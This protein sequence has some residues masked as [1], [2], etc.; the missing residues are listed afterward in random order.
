MPIELVLGLLL[1][2]CMISLLSAEDTFWDFSGLLTQQVVPDSREYILSFLP[3]CNYD[4]L[5]EKLVTYQ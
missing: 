1:R 2:K 5:T 3:S 4:N